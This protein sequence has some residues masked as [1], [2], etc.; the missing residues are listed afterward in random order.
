MIGYGPEDNHFVL[1]LTYNYGISTYRHGDS[2]RFVEILKKDVSSVL[3]YGAKKETGS[4]GDYYTAQNNGYTFR[5][6]PTTGGN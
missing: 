2:L 5:I 6:I 1:E 3:S 4:H